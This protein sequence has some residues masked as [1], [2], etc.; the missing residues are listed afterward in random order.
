MA[1]THL[2]SPDYPICIVAHDLYQSSGDHA[3]D[4]L[5]VLVLQVQSPAASATEDRMKYLV[6][7]GIHQVGG[8]LVLGEDDLLG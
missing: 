8:C 1:R 7:E 6:P 4:S 2:Y 3:N 5:L